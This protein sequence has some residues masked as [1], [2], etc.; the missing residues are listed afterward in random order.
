MSDDGL[1][2]DG[3]WQQGHG[4]VFS[5]QDPAAGNPTWTGN[6]ASTE[7][8]TAAVASARAAFPAWAD[9]DVKERSAILQ[10][11][12]RQMENARADLVHAI[13]LDTGKP[14]WEA[15]TEVSAMIRK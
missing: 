8:V 4:P 13:T 3:T 5:A 2:I 11:Y 6:A 9:R 14:R 1:F 10:E 7:D 12:A 15:D